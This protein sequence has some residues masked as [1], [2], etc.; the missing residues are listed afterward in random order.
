MLQQKEGK[1][2]N[3]N[4]VF[5]LGLRFAYK[6]FFFFV[7]RA[8]GLSNNYCNIV[9]FIG[10]RNIVTIIFIANTPLLLLSPSLPPS[11]SLFLLFL[12]PWPPLPPCPSLFC[13][14]LCS[15]RPGYNVTMWTVEDG[16]SP[17]SF[18]PSCDIC[19]L[20]GRGQS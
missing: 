4:T 6:F 16:V 7:F 2:K 19:M 1:E 14:C 8:K 10:Q 17:R 20:R 5:W 15:T 18:H 11:L 13:L 9:T 12:S 3:T